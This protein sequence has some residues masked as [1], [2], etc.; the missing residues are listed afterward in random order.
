MNFRRVNV[1]AGVL[2][3]LLAAVGLLVPTVLPNAQAAPPRPV[4]TVTSNASSA[5]T[6]KTTAPVVVT[7]RGAHLFSVRLVALGATSAVSGSVDAARTRWVST[8]E[9]TPLTAYRLTA[10]V[11]QPAPVAPSA[12]A[13]TRK[14]PTPAPVVSVQALAT[15]FRTGAPPK[16]IKAVLATPAPKSVVG[17]GMPV[18]LRFTAPVTDRAAVQRRLRVTT[19]HP[20][21]PAAWHWMSSTEVHYRPQRY[22]PARTTITVTAALRG[23]RAGAGTWGVDG[24]TTT[25]ST[26]R[27]QVLRITNSTHRLAVILDGKVVRSLPVSLGKRGFET[28]SGV[29]ILLDKH[30]SVR[31]RSATIGIPQ[32]SP[33]AYDLTVPYAMRMTASGEFIH[34]APWNGSIGFA[35]RSHGCT[36]LRLADARWLFGV[37]LPGDPVET[38]GTRRRMETR[39]GLGGDWNV[40]WAVW[41]APRR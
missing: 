29:K 39:N 28:R 32:G 26:G 20:T 38:S 3:S 30:L 16:V 6:W 34:G 14:A 41:S 17:V 33:E 21:G 22:W 7:A 15:T 27:A 4:Y 9:L 12:V 25:F 1:R 8:T 36:N 19:S 40:A 37:M 2:G 11:A 24:R 31:M 10:S 23:V 35:N 18:V 13:T 5:S